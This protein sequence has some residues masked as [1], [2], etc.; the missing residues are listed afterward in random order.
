MFYR[1]LS[2][3]L[4]TTNRLLI[5]V[6]FDLFISYVGIFVLKLGQPERRSLEGVVDG[7]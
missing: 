6:H 2:G 4:S 1:A 5:F 3:K 7:S